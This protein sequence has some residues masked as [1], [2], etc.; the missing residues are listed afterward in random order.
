[1]AIFS[2][3]V[4]AC[5]YHSMLLSLAKFPRFDVLLQLYYFLL[6]CSLRENQGFERANV[7]YSNFCPIYFILSTAA[8]QFCLLLVTCQLQLTVCWLR[9]SSIICKFHELTISETLVLY[10]GVCSWN[11]AATLL[12]Q[13]GRYIVN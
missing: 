11:C 12:P 3:L 8:P 2:L 4:G 10:F 1:M 13:T 9:L 5:M 7:R 6:W